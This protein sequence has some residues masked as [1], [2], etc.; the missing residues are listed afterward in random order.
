MAKGPQRDERWV[1]LK[2]L[3][4]ASKDALTSTLRTRRRRPASE[5]SSP[6]PSPPSSL[7]PEVEAKP[8]QQPP[9]DRDAPVAASDERGCQ[10]WSFPEREEEATTQSQWDIRR[11]RRRRWGWRF[12]LLFT[13]GPWLL[14][15]AWLVVQFLQKGLQ[16]VIPLAV[17]SGLGLLGWSLL[18]TTTHQIALHSVAMFLVEILDL[19]ERGGPLERY[20]REEQEKLL[21]E[22]TARM[23]TEPEESIRTWVTELQAGKETQKRLSPVALARQ[24]LRAVTF[25]HAPPDPTLLNPWRTA[26]ISIQ[27]RFAVAHAL[28]HPL[29]QRAIWLG[30]F[31]LWLLHEQALVVLEGLRHGS[32]RFVQ[33]PTRRIW[34][35]LTP[36]TYPP[37]GCLTFFLRFLWRHAGVAYVPADSPCF[38]RLF[39]TLHRLLWLEPFTI[40]IKELQVRSRDG[41]WLTVKGLQVRVRPRAESPAFRQFL[42]EALWREGAKAQGKPSRKDRFRQ[43]VEEL[44][45]S[46]DGRRFLEENVR[47]VVLGQVNRFFAQHTAQQ[48][49]TFLTEEE[50]ALWNA[51]EQELYQV[52]KT[53]PPVGLD[54]LRQAITQALQEQ[55]FEVEVVPPHV[56]LPQE[57]QDQHRHLREAFGLLRQMEKRMWEQVHEVYQSWLHQILTHFYAVW[58]HTQGQTQQERLWAFLGAGLPAFREAYRIWE[59]ALGEEQYDLVWKALEVSPVEAQRLR[60]DWLANYLA[61]LQGYYG[62]S[63]FVE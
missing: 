10:S 26:I 38:N 31:H 9:E 56:T 63:T 39:E 24:Y 18:L 2:I 21:Q 14:W 51:A 54:A 37:R 1:L 30:G 62:Y 11:L 29:L 4:G 20:L 5:A 60:D 45:A 59:E 46:V 19:R 13:W 44:K 7:P 28:H 32:L 36:F 27:D 35:R 49:T 53:F 8:P 57:L 23:E 48:V 15:L 50:R 40:R 41:L 22:L 42:Q 3:L 47:A 43:W 16:A 52:P 25:G 33:G 34:G 58:V 6:P 61:W 12:Y 55:G 17:A